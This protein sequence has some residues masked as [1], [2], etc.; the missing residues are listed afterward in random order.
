MIGFK[1]GWRLTSLTCS[2]SIQTSRPSRS[3]AR[4]CS[5]VRI[6]VFRPR[7]WSYWIKIAQCTQISKIVHSLD[8][9]RDSALGATPRIPQDSSE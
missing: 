8:L 6:I 4:Y 1:A 5:P 2:P 7:A 9:H 3:P